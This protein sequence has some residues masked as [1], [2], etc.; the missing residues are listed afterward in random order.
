[1]FDLNSQSPSLALL[2]HSRHMVRPTQVI[3]FFDR[4]SDEEA[5]KGSGGDTPSRLPDV[6]GETAPLAGKR[7]NQPRY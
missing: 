7:G 4:V 2:A 1:V 3:A 6:P 5:M